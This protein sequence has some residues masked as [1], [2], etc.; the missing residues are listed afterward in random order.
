MTWPRSQSR[1][2]GSWRSSTMPGPMT[3]K[4]AVTNPTKGGSGSGFGESVLLALAPECQWLP[5]TTSRRLT[6]R[7]RRLSRR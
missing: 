6:K 2:R 3:W 4:V 7:P 1:P 5:S